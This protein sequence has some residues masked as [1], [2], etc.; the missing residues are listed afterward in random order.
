METIPILKTGNLKGTKKK[1]NVSSTALEYLP[2]ELR[3]VVISFLDVK[4]ILHTVSFLSKKYRKYASDNIV[5]F[6]LCR[7]YI[8]R[9]EEVLYVE[10]RKRTTIRIA[11]LWKSYFIEK[12]LIAKDNSFVFSKSLFPPCIEPRYRHSCTLIKTPDNESPKIILIGGSGISKSQTFGDLFMLEFKQAE[13]VKQS[14]SVFLGDI[15]QKVSSKTNN[16][17]QK[18]EQKFIWKSNISVG[19][20][21][22]FF[23][24]YNL[25]EIEGKQPEFKTTRH[26][27][28]FINGK[29]WIWGGSS[30]LPPKKVNDMI[31]FDFENRFWEKITNYNGTPPSERSDHC[32]ASVGSNIYIFGGSDFNVT[33][34][35]DLH[36]FNT[37]TLTWTKIQ[38]KGTPPSPRS[39][40]SCVALGSMIYFFGGAQW[41]AKLNK[42]NSKSN[43]IFMFD[44]IETKW[45]KINALG[46][47]PLVSTF[48]AMVAVGRSI[49]IIGGGRS[50]GDF[51]SNSCYIFDT[52]TWAWSSVNISGHF[53]AKDC[54]T[55]TVYGSNV[56]LFGGFCGEPTNELQI[57]EMAWVTK[58]KNCGLDVTF[59]QI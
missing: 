30:G 18:V 34:L 7:R 3:L 47:V 43:E 4:T 50:D 39:G 6:E 5:W 21:K 20:H 32:M 57:L 12:Y 45:T 1:F 46:K 2:K 54:I 19:N 22:S 55:A 38:G 9:P 14:I 49:Y 17:E 13:S 53:S 28:C 40:H 10:E 48:A 35:N 36:V 15:F 27:S 31:S 42:W 59:L 29:I 26:T 51:V 58:M 23:K 41:N 37:D 56:F 33:P 16:V 11:F 52:I 24:I 25:I 44:T 8:W